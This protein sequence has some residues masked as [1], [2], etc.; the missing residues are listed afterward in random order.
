MPRRASTLA[1]VVFALATTQL[2]CATGTE[3]LTRRVVSTGINETLESL[4][5]ADNQ[6]LMRQ[7]V[8]L[9]EVQKAA[10]DLAEAISGGALDGLTDDE[11][12][13]KLRQLTDKFVTTISTSIARDLDA[14]ITPSLTNAVKDIVGGAVGAALS[15]ENRQQAKSFVDAITR[16]TVAAF[17]QSTGK[18]L[19]DDLGPAMQQVIEQNLGP[20]LENLIAKHLVPALQSALDDQAIPAAG[21]LARE[22]TRQSVL[23]AHDALVELQVDQKLGS[24][25]AR[26]DKLFNQGQQAGQT[27]IWIL[28]LV[29]VLLGIWLARQIIVR[30]DLEQERASSER[31]LLNVLQA[32]QR[33]DT[34]DPSKPPD[35]DTMIA[36]AS[37]Q[38]QEGR[39]SNNYLAGLVARARAAVTTG[40]TANSTARRPP[41]PPSGPDS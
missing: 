37:A 22:V 29:I 13:A 41:P 25:D 9:P 33:G 1:A 20:A 7:L 12:A 17:G 27:A 16:T 2:A 14:H 11:R 8:D 39:T 10:H 32:I 30:R 34:D 31:M 4:N 6:K 36:Q 19:R 18:V 38:A 26:L 21:K 15:P 40:L 23:G 5:D 3:K 24:I 35:L 28:V